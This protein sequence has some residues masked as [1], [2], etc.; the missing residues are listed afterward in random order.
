ML[1][2]KC[3]ATGS[4]GNC[5][6]L[7]TVTEA[8]ILDC[9]ILKK[10]IIAGLDYEVTKVKG[11]IISHGHKDHLLAEKDLFA[12]DSWKPFESENLNQKRTFGSFEVQSF[13]L[14]HNGTKNCGFYIKVDGQKI[15]Y[16]TDFEYCKYNFKNLNINHLIIECNYDE[17][18]S[19]LPNYRHKILGHCSLET[20]K[21]FI[22]SNYTYSLENVILV[23]MGQ[24]SYTYSEL[25]EK[26]KEV[27]KNA[28][29][30]YARIGLHVELHKELF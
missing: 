27:S 26:V 1:K 23:H 19:E 5:Y 29:V 20:C 30:Y 17:V 10:E 28:D 7:E 12:F 4:K 15:L 3:L 21:K 13:E 22:E 9:G 2:F 25:V 6:I 16:M 8:L 24:F 18:D 11:V 14:P